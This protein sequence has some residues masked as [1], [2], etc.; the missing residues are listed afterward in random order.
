MSLSVRHRQQ[1]LMDDPDLDDQLHHQALAGL[2]RIN[3]ISGTVGTIWKP[4]EQLAHKRAGTIRILDVACG[5]GDTA[6]ALAR[7]A[8]RARLP[9]QV[10]G[11]DLSST[12]ISYATNNAESQ[13]VD[14]RFF[15]ADA[16]GNNLPTGYD[17][18]YCSLF[19]HHLDDEDVVRLFRS[20]KT[21]AG[22]LVLAS[23]LRRSRLGYVLAWAGTRLLTRSRICHVDGP[24]SVEGA[25]TPR[26]ILALAAR[27]GLD[28]PQL[29]RHWPQRFLLRWPRHV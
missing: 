21:A 3:T 17:V 10:A 5:G 13:G 9:M 29:T 11:C 19:L 27:A 24:L 1:E 22:Q 28:H 25:F 14:V 15:Q 4:I 16:L 2:R 23:D 18:I 8:Q 7:R 26:E 6:I 12:A 20:M